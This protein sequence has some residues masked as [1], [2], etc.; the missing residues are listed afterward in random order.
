MDV[1]VGDKPCK[2]GVAYEK[3]AAIE[4]MPMGYPNSINQVWV[5]QRR[6]TRS[7]CWFEQMVHH[8]QYEF[9]QNR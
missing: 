9:Y 1:I 6:P 4:F 2:D 7:D 3:Y 5:H 8:A